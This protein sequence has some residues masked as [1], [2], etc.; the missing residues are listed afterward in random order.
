MQEK[1]VVVFVHGV[2]MT[3]IESTALRMRLAEKFS[4]RQFH[5]RSVHAEMAD[6]AA[7]LHEFS[8]TID[9]DEIHYV[10]HS[11][12]GLVIMRMFE[13][14]VDRKP[15]RIVT[16][17]APLNGS[18][19]AKGLA[20]WPGGRWMLGKSIGEE[21]LGDKQRSWN[22]NHDLGSLAGDAGVG[23]GQYLGPLE[24]PH[25]GTVSVRETIIEGAADHIVMPVN[26]TTML[27]SADVAEQ[28]EFFIRTGKFDH[29]G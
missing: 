16:L 20:R 28:V 26:H 14:F 5:Y 13:Q 29:S 17:G 2:W 18:G 3:G 4:T 10:G 25:D 24:A 23:I 22:G 15:G 12:G 21:L 19:A 6:N 11:L 9:A 8:K 7:W 1:S 27:F